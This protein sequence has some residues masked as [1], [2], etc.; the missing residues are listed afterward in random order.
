VQYHLEVADLALPA[1]IQLL[2]YQIARE[3]IQNAVKHA[4]ASN[5]WVTLGAADQDVELRIRDDG[6]GFDSSQPSPE[7]HYGLSIM[8]ERAYI[9]GGSLDLKSAPGEGTSLTVRFH[10]SWLQDVAEP[11]APREKD[12]ATPAAS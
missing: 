1:P 5:I 6:A 12:T 3:A 9:G 2:S 8:R 4:D 7:G 10:R 11:A